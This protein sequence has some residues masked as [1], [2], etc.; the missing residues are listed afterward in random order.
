MAALAV[1]TVGQRGRCADGPRRDFGTETQWGT[2]QSS[3]SQ[4]HSLFAAVVAEHSVVANFG[5]ALGQ[6]V[7]QETADK[8]DPGQGQGLEAI[9]VSVV[10]IGKDHR[11]SAGV[12]GAQARVA[13]GHAVSVAAEVVQDVLGSHDGTFGENDPAPGP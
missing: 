2:F 7:Q 11:A 8:F 13:D 6:D 1:R 9:G 5:E 12:D 10:F 3:A 4:T